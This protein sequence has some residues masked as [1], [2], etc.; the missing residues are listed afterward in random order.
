MIN[1]LV[2]PGRPTPTKTSTPH[3]GHSDPGGDLLFSSKNFKN[4]FTFNYLYV[5]IYIENERSG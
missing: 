4:H 3:P 2:V 5:I 1:A